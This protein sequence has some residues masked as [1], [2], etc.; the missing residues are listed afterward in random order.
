[1][2]IDN[3]SLT[4]TPRSLMDRNVKL[5]SEHAGKAK[6]MH[7]LKEE[8]YF[9]SCTVKIKKPDCVAIDGFCMLHSLNKPDSMKTGSDLINS[10]CSYV[11]Q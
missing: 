1:M 10:V 4:V 7:V 11:E 9:K 5:I 3:H 2:I 6:L 8:I